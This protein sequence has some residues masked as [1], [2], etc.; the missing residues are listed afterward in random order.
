MAAHYN[1]KKNR[2]EKKG[3]CQESL[4]TKQLSTG[5]SINSKHGTVRCLKSMFQEI[6]FIEQS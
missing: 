2:R 6:T 3:E 4:F 5:Q 1:R